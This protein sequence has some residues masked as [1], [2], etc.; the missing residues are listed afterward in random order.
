MNYGQQRNRHAGA[1]QADWRLVV[2]HFDDHQ[3]KAL[4]V[5]GRRLLDPKVETVRVDQFRERLDQ[6][7]EGRRWTEPESRPGPCIDRSQDGH[8]LRVRN[9]GEVQTMWSACIERWQDHIFDCKIEFV[10]KA[11]FVDRTFRTP[12]QSPNG[13]PMKTSVG[14][15]LNLVANHLFETLF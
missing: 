4:R 13:P 2:L 3:P 15:V 14:A 12:S 9:A 6:R 10:I 8:G 5:D 11:L 1:R 7:V